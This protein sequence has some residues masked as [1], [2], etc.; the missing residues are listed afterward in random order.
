VPTAVGAG[1]LTSTA[2]ETVASRF[3][4]ILIDDERAH[5]LPR[6]SILLAAAAAAAAPAASQGR[7]QL[8]LLAAAVTAAR[9][10]LAFSQQPEKKML[11]AS[12]KYRCPHLR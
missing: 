9:W 11:P 2:A 12:Y 6:H 10:Q 4:L 5:R 7:I 3:L 1:K 8:L